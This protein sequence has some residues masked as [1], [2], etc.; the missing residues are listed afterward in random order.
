MSKPIHIDEN[1]IKEWMTIL[2]KRADYIGALGEIPVTAVVLDEKGR[3]IGHGGNRRVR[4]ADPMGHAEIAAIRQAAWIKNDWRLNDCTLIVTLEPC[5]MCSAALIQARVGQVIYG[6]SDTKRGGLGGTI[7]LSKQ[8]SSHHKIII[9][10]GFLEEEVS[11]QIKN[12]F[13]RKRANN[14][15]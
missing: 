7:D 12:W 2:I 14:S 4:E 11:Y 13:K 6:A 3:C 15:I 5:T 1:K 9:Q 8:P 10:R